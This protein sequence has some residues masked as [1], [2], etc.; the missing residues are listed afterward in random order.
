MVPEGVSCNGAIVTNEV[1]NPASYKLE[2]LKANKRREI[3]RAL[4]FL[5]ISRVEKI[6]DLLGD[7][8]RVYLN[9]AKRMHS[10]GPDRCTP[11]TLDES[12]KRP[13]QISP[14][15]RAT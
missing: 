2:S 10:G 14:S 9:W 4:A 13:D 12:K 15:S 6:D 7:G 8:F 1:S 11:Q 5:R 3:R